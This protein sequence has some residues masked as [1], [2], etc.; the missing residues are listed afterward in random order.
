MHVGDLVIVIQLSISKIEKIKI[1]VSYNGFFSSSS[2][3]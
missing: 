3:P 2:S 1:A